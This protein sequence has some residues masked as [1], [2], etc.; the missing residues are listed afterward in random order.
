MIRHITK[1]LTRTVPS[2][3]RWFSDNTEKT[4]HFG[5]RTIPQNLKESLVSK[6]FQN[7]AGNYDVMNDFMSGGIHRLWKNEFVSRLDAG[8]G[9]KLLDVAGGTGDIAFRFLESLKNQHGSYNGHVTVLDIN[10][11]MLQVGQQR[12]NALGLLGP[13]L[14]F[15]EG[16]AEHLNI[17][18]SSVDAYTIAFGIRNCTNIDAVLAEAYRVL[19]PG[20]RF[21]CLEFSHPSNPLIA[22]FM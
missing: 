7:V 12:A 5:F 3:G 17:A 19:K 13:H 10:P 21:M 11:S 6:V 1:T 16:N 4:T 8:A 20:G 14:D 22:R 15:M 2:S 18:D 9:T